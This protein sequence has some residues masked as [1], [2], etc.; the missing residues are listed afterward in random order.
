[1]SLFDVKHLFFI[2]IIIYS[3]FGSSKLPQCQCECCPG[4]DCR[5]HLLVF[6]VD[7]CNET[8]CSFE[9][10]YRM[11]PKKCGLIP[12]FTDASCSFRIKNGTTSHIKDNFNTT[13][14]N[15][16]STTFTISATVIMVNLFFYFLL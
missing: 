1:M 8:T 16:T 11:Y 15:R 3:V 10:C 12:G 5:S 4:E 14:L 2:L 7:H 9:Q 6:S 13:L